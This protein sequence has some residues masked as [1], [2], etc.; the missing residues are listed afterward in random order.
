[1]FY[2]DSE[3]DATDVLDCNNRIV[4]A[5]GFRFRI[6]VRPGYPNLDPADITD[7]LKN[8]IKLALNKRFIE[9]N[10]AIDLKSFHRDEGKN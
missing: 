1:M 4:A 8:K 3:S 2:L 10:N 9:A 7:E 6:I 5:D